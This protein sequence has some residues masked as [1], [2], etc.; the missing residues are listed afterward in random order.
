MAEHRQT[1]RNPHLAREVVD[2]DIQLDVKRARVD[3]ERPPWRAVVEDGT[4]EVGF[5]VGQPH[6]DRTVP[7]VHRALQLDAV[8]EGNCSRP[9]LGYA[10]RGVRHTAGT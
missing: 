4:G 5:L 6:L 3:P 1:A 10:R 9:G 8:S 7:S 2:A